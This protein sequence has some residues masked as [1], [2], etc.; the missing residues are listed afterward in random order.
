MGSLH[1]SRQLL[2]RC[3]IL[4]PCHLNYFTLS[5]SLYLLVF[6]PSMRKNMI[7]IMTI[8]CR[9]IYYFPCRN[10]KCSTSHVSQ[11]KF[12]YKWKSAIPELDFLSKFLIPNAAKS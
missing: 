7:M 2:C 3:S 8:V 6:L 9:I 1:S 12:Y 11:F 5:K 10:N 4:C